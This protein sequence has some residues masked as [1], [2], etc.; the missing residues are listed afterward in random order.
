M[1]TRRKPSTHASAVARHV[2]ADGCQ[3]VI[4]RIGVSAGQCFSFVLDD[5][6]PVRGTVRWVVRDRIGFAFDRPISRATQMAML[7]RSKVVQGLDLQ[8]A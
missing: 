2:T 3:F 1:S 8:P 4:E 7:R 6:P 5:H